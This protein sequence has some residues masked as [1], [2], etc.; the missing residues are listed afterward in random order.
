MRR[1]AFTI[2]LLLA[3]TLVAE[4]FQ[5]E[6][7]QRL[8]HIAQRSAPSPAL[9][10]ESSWHAKL[11]EE[12]EKTLEWLPDLSSEGSLAAAAGLLAQEALHAQEPLQMRDL[13]GER[14]GVGLSGNHVLRFLSAEGGCIIKAMRT[15]RAEFLQEVLATDLLQRLHLSHLQTISMLGVAQWRDSATGVSFVLLAESLAS[16]RALESI[17]IDLIL[18]PRISTKRQETFAKL[19]K[20]FLHH[21]LRSR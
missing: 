13:R 18:M 14:P 9:D 10:S 4:P 11:V 5:E 12:A 15:S 16:G 21:K 3:A 17:I 19:Q 6:L 2:I 7:L 8:V 1:S 20:I